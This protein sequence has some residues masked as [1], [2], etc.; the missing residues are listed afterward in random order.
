MKKRVLSILIAVILIIAASSYVFAGENLE[1][2]ETSFSDI[3]GH[4]AE[5]TII[6]WQDKGILN[7]YE[8][9]TFRPDDPITR[10]ELAKIITLAFDL[11]ETAELSYNDLDTAAWYYPYV[12]TGAEYIPVYAPPD[13]TYE[14]MIYSQSQQKSF[15]PDIPALRFHIAETFSLLKTEKDSLTVEFPSIQDVHDAVTKDFKDVEYENLYVMH[16]EVP[17]NVQ[18]MQNY[19]WLVR[20]L[21]IMH[22]DE[23]GYFRPYKGITRAELIT[24]LDRIL[25]DETQEDTTSN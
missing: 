4:W 12:Q 9:G 19:T 3:S 11:T 18:R 10:A 6:K 15:L 14:T 2:H 8:D 22:G 5:S 24:V 1:T 25:S 7:G 20:E 16:G 17:A 13:A 23:D 21:D